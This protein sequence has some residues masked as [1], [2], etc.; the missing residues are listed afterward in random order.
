VPFPDPWAFDVELLARLLHPGPGVEPVAA[1][2]VLEVPLRA[3]RDVAGS[4]V[5]P[6]AS[7]RAA[8]AL[9]GV[10]RRIR[11]RSAARDG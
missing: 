9:A 3:W 11:E 1:D 2:A 8:L 4:K 5:R 10:H 6:L 7:L